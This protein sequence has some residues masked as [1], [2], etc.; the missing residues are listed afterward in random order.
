MSKIVKW[1]Y[2][3][4]AVFLGYEPKEPAPNRNQ[5]RY[6]ITP[7]EWQQIEDLRARN[8][9]ICKDCSKDRQRW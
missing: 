6:Y 7:K 4:E 1:L 9:R 5:N 8:T 2:S 3:N